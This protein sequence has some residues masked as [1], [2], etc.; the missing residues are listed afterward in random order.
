VKLNLHIAQ[1]IRE[2]PSLYR[3]VTYEKSRL[4]VLDQLFFV[5]GNGYEWSPKGILVERKFSGEKRP[6]VSRSF[7]F[8]DDYWTKPLFETSYLTGPEGFTRDV[9]ARYEWI[10]YPISDYSAIVTIPDHV[11]L[12]WLKGAEEVYEALKIFWAQDR[13]TL[14]VLFKGRR[15][16]TDEQR[17]KY[18]DSEILSQRKWV[19]RID[20]RLAYF[21]K[22]RIRRLLAK[23]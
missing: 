8:D 6:K 4:K 12:D 19:E 13:E 18:L 20:V 22:E 11:A 3:D 10:P 23:V 7:K 17:E 21:R 9:H 16:W 2:Y 5:I 15:G 1:A 14:N